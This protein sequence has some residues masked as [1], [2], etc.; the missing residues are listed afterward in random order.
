MGNTHTVSFWREDK[1]LGW[2]YEDIY[3]GESFFTAFLEFIKAKKQG[4]VCVKWEYS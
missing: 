4:K 3:R 2:G 1:V